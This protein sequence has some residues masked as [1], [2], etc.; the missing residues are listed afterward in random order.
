MTIDVSSAYGASAA[1]TTPPAK[2]ATKELDKQAFLQLLTTQLRN[3]DPSSPMDSSDLMAQTTQMSTMEQLI[4]LTTTSRESFSLQMRMAAANLV[5]HTVTYTGADGKAATGTVSAVSYAGPVPVVK[6][7]DT[8]VPLDSVGSVTAA[9]AAPAA[10]PAAPAPAPA[11]A[12][13]TTTA[14]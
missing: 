3:Q 14:S 7:G 5:G 6:V 4:E 2:A 13:P 10:T 8:E 11:P 1:A 12:A 9:T